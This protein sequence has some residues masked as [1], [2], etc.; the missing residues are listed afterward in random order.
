MD[1]LLADMSLAPISIETILSFFSASLTGYF[2]FVKSR[3]E[4]PNLKCLQIRDFRVSLRKSQQKEGMKTFGLMQVDSGGVLIA[5]DSTRQTSIVKFDCSF[6]HNGQTHRGR[7]GYVD[8]DKPPWNIGPESTIAMSLACFFEVPEDFEA[9]ENLKFKVD[10]ITP[11]G[12]RFGKVFYRHT[13][14]V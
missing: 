2:W 5:N 8:D 7:W 4:R 13:P 1:G 6:E 9:P 11:T 3:R 14:E 10:F 12:K